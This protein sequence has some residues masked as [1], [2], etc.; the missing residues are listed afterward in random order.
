MLTKINRQN[1]LNSYPKFPLRKY[2]PIQDDETFFYPRVFASYI[3][4]LE[5]KSFKGHI[6]TLG[7]E[8][9]RLAKEMKADTLIFLGDT[10]TSWLY[11]ENDF[12]PAKEAFQFLV[13]NKV[14]KKFNGALQTDI[15][16][17][18]IFIKHLSW[19]TR[20]NAALPYIYFSDPGQNFIGNICKYGNLHFSTLHAKSD[21]ALKDFIL[22]S[23]FKFLHDPCYNQF[24]KTSAISGRRS[25]V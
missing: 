22:K 8:L 13:D 5:S 20:C 25:V 10:D 7:L 1:C 2:D 15:A 4:T 6:K 11:Q 18:P 24:G 9:S 23:K 19:L 14:G 12:K 17:L 21:N 16:T 3:L